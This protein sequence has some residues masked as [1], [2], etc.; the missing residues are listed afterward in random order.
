MS[1]AYIPVWPVQTL[2]TA[3]CGHCGGVAAGGAR[4]LHRNP[5]AAGVGLVLGQ[6]CGDD[7]RVDHGEV[8]G[9]AE[10]VADRRRG[11]DY[12]SLH[13]EAM[14]TDPDRGAGDRTEITL[15]RGGAGG[16]ARTVDEVVGASGGEDGGAG[17]SEIDGKVLGSGGVGRGGTQHVVTDNGE[18]DADLAGRRGGGWGRRDGRR[19]GR[20]RQGGLAGRWRGVRRAQVGRRPRARRRFQSGR[21]GSSCQRDETATSE[22]PIGGQH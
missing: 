9:V 16:E 5:H 3:A 7:A 18:G 1:L 22:G 19:T 4:V 20:R 14:C 6:M 17:G 21:E 2:L 13:A 12:V 10:G 15:D 8:R 11:G